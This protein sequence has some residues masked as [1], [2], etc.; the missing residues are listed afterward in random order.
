MAGAV[1]VEG[2][3]ELRKSLSATDKGAL[4]EVQA[5]TKRAA[6]VVLSRAEVNARAFRRTG[7]LAGSGKA[8]TSG[9]KGVVRFTVPY[10]K[11]HEYGGTIAPRGTP[12][13]IKRR[14]FVG[15]A[16]DSEQERVLETFARGFDDLAKRSGWK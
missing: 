15:H 14:E 2:L 8:S 13:K 11:V 12:I 6:G 16:L 7:R 10:A 1:R 5:I 4:K 3:A 9:T